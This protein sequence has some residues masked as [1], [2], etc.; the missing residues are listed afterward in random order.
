MS[1]KILMGSIIAVAI[2]IG[3][4]FTSVVGFQ[5]VK[6][7]PIKASPLF[8]V[9]TKRAIDEESKDLSC[10][11]V[12][13]GEEIDIPIPTRDNKIA[14]VQKLVDSIS[15]MDDVTFNRFV[16]LVICKIQQNKEFEAVDIDKI[17]IF[18]NQFRNYPEKNDVY[19]NNENGDLTWYSTPTLCWFPTCLF[20][21]F[22]FP[23]GIK[24]EHLSIKT[25]SC[26][27]NVNALL[28]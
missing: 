12:G 8:T 10:D 28:L 23:R 3:V 7:N 24:K 16:N 26:F 9:R 27:A 13:M 11:Y 1:N 17:I 22:I 4:S 18:F 15:K 20:L 5:S 21:G 14:L 19:Y 2:L 6:S 25:Y